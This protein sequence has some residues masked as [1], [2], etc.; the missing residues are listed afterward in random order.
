MAER[1]D[2]GDGQWV[3]L[4]DPEVMTNRQRRPYMD[5]FF[6]MKNK[7]WRPDEDAD[8]AWKWG[9]AAAF[10][11]ISE[12]S[13]AEELPTEFDLFAMVCEELPVGFVDRMSL[14]AT[15]FLMAT[16]EDPPTT[17]G[18]KRTP[19]KKQVAKKKT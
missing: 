12:W 11:L 6:K 14:A 10:M 19:A 2:L 7:T 4:R 17:P 3:V 5:L 13:R 18:T 1:I 8:S 15:Q 16:V 9:L